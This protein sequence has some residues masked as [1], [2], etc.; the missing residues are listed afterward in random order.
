MKYPVGGGVEI[1]E[2]VAR[3]CLGEEVIFRMH[4]VC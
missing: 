3:E 1:L 4:L 2:R